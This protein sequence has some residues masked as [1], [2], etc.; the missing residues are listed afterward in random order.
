MNTK[1]NVFLNELDAREQKRFEDRGRIKGLPFFQ[2]D[3]FL[4]RGAFAVLAYNNGSWSL[5][6]NE[7]PDECFIVLYRNLPS[8]RIEDWYKP[9]FVEV[10]GVLGSPVFEMGWRFARKIAPAL[11]G[12]SDNFI[13]PPSH[14]KEDNIFSKYCDLIP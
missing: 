13:V 4:G 6:D 7:T 8:V 5:W 10:V 11:Q 14:S 12:G 3:D 9:V 1:I 2:D